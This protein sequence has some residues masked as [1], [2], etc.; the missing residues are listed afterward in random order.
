MA[1]GDG[2]LLIASGPGRM[3]SRTSSVP[4]TH[5]DLWDA[6]SA[7]NTVH[8]VDPVSWTT[9]LS[10]HPI[11]PGFEI[12]ELLVPPEGALDPDPSRPLRPDP[13]QLARAYFEATKRLGPAL[14]HLR[15]ETAEP[16]RG[17]GAENQAGR[18]PARDRRAYPTRSG[19]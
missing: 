3:V 17:Q 11:L 13:M 8:G 2:N 12:F 1:M 6:L 16:N 5:R 10:W 9:H 15:G 18:M 4:P 7:R 14:A 19:G